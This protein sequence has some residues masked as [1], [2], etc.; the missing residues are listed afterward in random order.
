MEIV[1]KKVND[2]IPYENNPRVI[3]DN[4]IEKVANSIKE[5]GIKQPIVIDKDNTIVVG[6]TRLRA[7]KKLG[8]KQVPC[9]VADD[10]T[11]EQIDAYRLADNKV[12]EFTDWDMGKLDSELLDITLDM[13]QFGFDLDLDDEEEDKGETRGKHYNDDETPEIEEKKLIYRIESIIK[14]KERNKCIELFAGRG[15]LSYWYKRNFK[16]VITNDKQTFED[17]KHSY[18]MTAK[19]FIKTEIENHLDFD[20]IDFDDEG[21]PAKEIQEFFKLIKDKKKGS[22]V[23]AITDGQGLNLK[24]KGK[25]NFFET[26]MIR[27][28]KMVQPQV[29]DYYDF[30]DIFRQFMKE[31]TSKNGFTCEELSMHLKENGN[32][33]YSTYLINN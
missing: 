5:F 7:C 12:A 24:S 21:C 13:E 30:V 32:V 16:E 20:Y 29:Q 4:A 8:I 1:N 22:F 14:L 19:K 3:D 2:L 11:K 18:N 15:A 28:D 9:V 23:I 33:I 6:H 10:L 25:I 31:V 26:Y 17:I 27:E